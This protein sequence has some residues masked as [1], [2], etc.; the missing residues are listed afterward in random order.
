MVFAATALSVEY[1]F[2]EPHIVKNHLFEAVFNKSLFRLF[3]QYKQ[4]PQVMHSTYLYIY[5]Y[6]DLH[7]YG[8]Y[9]NYPQPR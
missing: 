7:A 5:A 8:N 9:Q 4:Q 1:Q 2:N 6:D 3:R